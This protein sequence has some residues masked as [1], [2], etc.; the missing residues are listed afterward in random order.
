MSS[1]P[2]DNPHLAMAASFLSVQYDA[3]KGE[4]DAGQEDLLANRKAVV[5]KSVSWWVHEEQATVSEL[6]PHGLDL[7][8]ALFSPSVSVPEDEVSSCSQRDRGDGTEGVQLLL[9]IT[10]L[11]HVILPVFV[12]N[13]AKNTFSRE[14]QQTVIFT[15][16][17]Q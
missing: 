15:A 14:T 6:Q 12:P 13:R 2:A 11:A 17:V 8:A 9:V 16:C 10:M 1:P 4:V 3:S 7:S 5:P